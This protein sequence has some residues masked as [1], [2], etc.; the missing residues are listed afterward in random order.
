MG[1]YVE[2]INWLGDFDFGTYPFN[3]C[4]VMILCQ[5]SYLDMTGVM[6][7]ESV[8]TLSECC[9]QLEK[10]KGLNI[11]MFCDN[12]RYTDFIRAAA[13]SKRFGSIPL[14]GYT[15]I[16]SD[17]GDVQFSA[18]TFRLND[19]KVFIAYRG[20]DETITGWKEDFMMSFTETEAQKLSLGY[21]KE[22]IPDGKTAFI[23]GHSKGGN[24]ALYTCAMLE[25]ELLERVEHI[26][27]LDGPGL[28]PDMVAPES[29]DRIRGK[30]TCI[31][32]E[33]SIVG[34][35]FEPDV[36]DTR[37]VCSDDEG[38]MQHDI[39]SWQVEAG[40]PKYAEKN[41][42]RSVWLDQVIDKWI[43]QIPP[44]ERK[45]FVEELFGA[46]A[47]DGSKT[48]GDITAKG[49]FGLE[50]TIM[51]LAQ[52]SDSVKF[53]ALG[54]PLQMLYGD[55]AK[56]IKEIRKKAGPVEWINRHG[57][58][59]YIGMILLGVFMMISPENIEKFIVI[60]F[61]LAVTVFQIAVTVKNLHDSAWNAEREQPRIY[62]CIAMVTALTAVVIKENALFVIGSMM[63][64]IGFLI[65]AFRRGR[66]F[67]NTKDDRFM[68]VITG[69]ETAFSAIYGISYLVIPQSTVYAY[70]ISVGAVLIADGVLRLARETAAAVKRHILR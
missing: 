28:C 60:G 69:A 33:Y 1:N 40:H 30:T 22:H 64:G 37:I 54:I 49:A 31:V 68:K 15:D 38:I 50:R 66:A 44:D 45:V 57:V 48:L 18:V 56:E 52:V 19:D 3:E 62:I 46:L 9:A 11:R 34:K 6:L 51:N 59:K 14:G 5:L 29:M 53:D 39:N 27:C 47:K 32:P 41:S 63:F 55:T 10:G 16:Y 24:L 17:D 4:D 12:S 65:E 35:L 58:L 26:Y 43:E 23:A 70:A 13:A 25:D 36:P 2:Y 20:T 7:P 61:F 42:Y 67:R 8:M 21:A